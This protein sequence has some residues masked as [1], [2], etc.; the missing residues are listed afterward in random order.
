MPERLSRPSTSLFMTETDMIPGRESKSIKTI[1]TGE[2][3]G[4]GAVS[5]IAS[6]A[7]ITAKAAKQKNRGIVAIL[8]RKRRS[9]KR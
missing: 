5:L 9:T 4:T 1:T 3:C 2:P 7:G 8:A 6:V